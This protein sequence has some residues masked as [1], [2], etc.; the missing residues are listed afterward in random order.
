M[1]MRNNKETIID[2]YFIVEALKETMLFDMFKYEDKE[3]QMND[4]KNY[5]NNKEGF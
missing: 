1:L 4:L 3:E 5:K 2:K